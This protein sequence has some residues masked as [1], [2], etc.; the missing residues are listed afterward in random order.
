MKVETEMSMKIIIDNNFFHNFNLFPSEL[1]G[2]I[3][4]VIL[5][6]M[7]M[8]LFSG[9]A[10][11]TDIASCSNPKGKTYYPY[12]GAV[13]K[14]SSGWTD[15]RISGGIVKLSKNEQDEFDIL[16]VDSAKR[17]VSSKEMGGQVVM[18][19]KGENE[20]S[21]FVYYPKEV[22]EV[23]TFL[24]NKDGKNEYVHITSRGGDMAMVTKSSI[25]RGDCDYIYH[26]LIQSE[27]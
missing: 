25:F 27:P 23:Y 22:V 7:G 19:N 15:D 9:T 16:F 11:A 10:F 24:T 20:V 13:T 14:K 21:F 18:L 6:V 1:K 5:L 4:K 12:L 26:N 3:M 2:K 8:A 17:I